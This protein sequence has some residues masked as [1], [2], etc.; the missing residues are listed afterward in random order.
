MKKISFIMIVS[1]L[2]I[3]LTSCV[4]TGFD[5]ELLTKEN[6]ETLDT[7]S[8]S[9]TAITLQSDI[10]ITDKKQALDIISKLPIEKIK[11][12]LQETYGITL[13]TS[14]FQIKNLESEV[15]VL[16]SDKGKSLDIWAWQHKTEEKIPSGIMTV[17]IRYYNIND[18]MMLSVSTSLF[19]SVGTSLAHIYYE[20]NWASG[21][22]VADKRTAA[23]VKFAKHIAPDYIIAKDGVETYA[24]YLQNN[25]APDGGIYVDTNYPVTIVTTVADP[26]IFMILDPMTWINASI[27][28]SYESGKTYTIKYDVDRS[29]FSKYDWKVNFSKEEN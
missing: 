8:F 28:E 29:T 26:G 4:S 21:H 19:D 9:L 14:F 17:G 7:K 18:P 25:E 10:N 1:L 27:N 5:K 6:V 2:I 22:T 12:D 15:G 13:D 3:S 24:S 16:V 23:I 11:S 20:N